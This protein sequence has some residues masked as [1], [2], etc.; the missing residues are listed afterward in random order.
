MGAA[1]THLSMT[2]ILTNSFEKRRGLANSVANIG[3]SAGGLIWPILL[4]ISLDF[5]GLAGTLLIVSGIM[6]QV[7]VCGALLRPLPPEKDEDNAITLVKDDGNIGC[8]TDEETKQTDSY[9][10]LNRTHTL[11]NFKTYGYQIRPVAGRRRTQSENLTECT[12]VSNL[13][14]RTATSVHDLQEGFG[15]LKI[16]SSLQPMGWLPSTERGEAYSQCRAKERGRNSHEI[17]NFSLFKNPLFYIFTLSSVLY[18]PTTAL[19]I[20]YIPPFAR[21]CEISDENVALLVTISAAS[22]VLGRIGLT[23][24]ADSKTL[25][26]HQILAITMLMNGLSCLFVQFYTNFPTLIIFCVIYGIFGQVYFSLY[27]VIIVDFLGLEN[28]RHGLTTV[29]LTMGSSI[30]LA[31]VIIGTCNT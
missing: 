23:F 6:F 2:L 25:K 29:T 31:T 24:I 3:G 10:K 4:K 12:K 5:Y 16:S 15:K 22:D 18:A 27:P 1:M 7:I 19:P 11:P 9:E 20:S 28:L 17:F 21:D 13:T 26:R 30:A 8:A 14:Q